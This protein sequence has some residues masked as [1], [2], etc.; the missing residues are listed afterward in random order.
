MHP[1]FLKSKIFA[2][3]ALIIMTLSFTFPMIAFHGTLNKI[4]ENKTSEISSLSISI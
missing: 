1:S 2:L 4:N 3:L